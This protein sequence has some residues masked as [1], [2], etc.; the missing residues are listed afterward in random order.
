MFSQEKKFELSY[1]ISGWY[2]DNTKEFNVGYTYSIDNNLLMGFNLTPLLSLG[3]STNYFYSHYEDKSVTVYTSTDLYYEGSNSKKYEI[4]IGP[5]AKLAY[6]KNYRVYL[7]AEYNISYGSNISKLYNEY[8][9]LNSTENNNYYTQ[10]LASEIGVGKKLSNCLYF[11]LFIKE[12]CTFM[13]KL[14]PINPNEHF[15]PSFFTYFGFGIV[16]YFNF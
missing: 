8:R 2:K 14:L 10:F 11:N 1:N 7:I 4:G 15:E 13:Y 6:G 12:Q 16:Y 5:Y 3:L 9:N